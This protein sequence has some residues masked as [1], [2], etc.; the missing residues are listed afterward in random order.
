MSDGIFV[1]QG[2][3]AQLNLT[4]ATVV[5]QGANSGFSGAPLGRAQRVSVIVA[6]TTAGGVFDSA[7]VGGAVAAAQLA[8]IPNV[9]GTYLVDMPFFKGLCVVPGTG[10]TLAISYD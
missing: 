2:K 9:V 10:Q 3:N 6:G 4:A 7:T 8:A 1:S 5:Q